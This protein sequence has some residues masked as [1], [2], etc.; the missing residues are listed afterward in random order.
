MLSKISPASLATVVVMWSSALV[1]TQARARV[2]HSEAD[3]EA[4]VEDFNTEL[5]SAPSPASAGPLS[6]GPESASIP[7][8]HA[9][10][11][12]QSLPVALPTVGL[13][14]EYLGISPACY[15]EH[16]CIHICAGY[17]STVYLPFTVLHQW[18]G[19]PMGVPTST[20][21]RS[22]VLPD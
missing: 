7:G 9:V 5:T 21:H 15:H 13:A 19:V 14:P 11:C 2:L 17:G 16:A 4:L 12:Q 20:P 18:M 22:H 8:A 10:H 3:M 1:A 6:E